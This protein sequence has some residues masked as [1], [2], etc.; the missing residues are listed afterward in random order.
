MNEVEVEPSVPV[1]PSSAAG[2]VSQESAA[3]PVGSPGAEA[4]ASAAPPVVPAPSE[5]PVMVADATLAVATVDAQAEVAA[6]AIPVAP[7]LVIVPNLRG[8]SLRKARRTLKEVG[9]KI[10]V[11]DSYGDKIPREYWS[12]YRVRRQK[13]EAGA[14][15]EPGSRVR[16]KARERIRAASGY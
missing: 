15:V 1:E 13:T 4:T 2:A 6:G 16:V 9:L 7:A 3:A 10:S 12:E 14:E 5:A 8:M 11:R